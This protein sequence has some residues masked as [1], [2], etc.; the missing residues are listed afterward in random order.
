MIGVQSFHLAAQKTE[1]TPKT[2]RLLAGNKA[3][4]KNE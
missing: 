3:L 2:E 4:L 1:A